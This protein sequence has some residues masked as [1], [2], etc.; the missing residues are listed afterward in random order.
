[1]IGSSLSHFKITAKLGEGGMG[2]V[3]QADD[4]KLGR[5]VA[6]KVLPEAVAADRERLAR[7]EREAKVLASLNHPNIAAIYGLEE[8]EDQ[9][10]LV[11]EMAD[12]ATLQELIEQGVP[13]EQALE[14]AG[15]V[16]EALEEAHDQGIVHRDLKPAN[17]K[18]ATNGKVKVLDFGLAKALD[19]QDSGTSGPSLS[20]SPTLTAQMTQAGVLLGTAAYM[21][22]EQARG[23]EATKQADIWAFGV[24]LWEML[25]GRQLFA[26]PTVSDTLAEVLKTDPDLGALPYETPANVHRVLRR[27]LE[28][29]PKKRLR[30]IGD[31][32]LELLEPDEPSRDLETEK[33]ETTSRPR[34]IIGLAGLLAG[35]ALGAALYSV[36]SVSATPAAREARSPRRSVLPFENQLRHPW[37]IAISPDGYSVAI[38]YGYGAEA[39]IELRNLGSLEGIPIPGSE[40]ALSP[41]FSPDGEWLAYFDD[42]ELRKVPVSGGSSSVVCEARTARSATWSDDGWIYFT[43]GE[44]RLARVPADGGESQDLTTESI[45]TPHALPEGRGVL[46]NISVGDTGSFRK[47]TAG[48]AVIGSDG[49]HKKLLDGG[50]AP[51]YLST[52]HLVFIRQGALFAVPFDVERLEVT[53]SEVQVLPRIWND[54]VWGV[55]TFDIGA[56]GTVVYVDGGNFAKTTPSWLDREGKTEPLN[57]PQNIHGTFQLS[58]DRSRLAIQIMEVEDQIHV[59]DFARR[60]LAQLTFD[61]PSRN[62]TW[63]HDGKEIFYAASREGRV[64]LARRSTDGIGEETLLLTADQ[65]ETME[66]DYV[67]PHTVSPDGRH[68]LLTSW[69]N[70]ETRADIWLLD[71]TSED[72]PQPLLKTEFNEIIPMFSPDGDYILYQSDKAGPYG[73]YVRPFPDVDQREWTISAQGGFDARW[74]PKG[75][76]ILYRVGA[77]RFMSVPYTMEPEFTPGAVSIVFDTDSHDSPG[78]SFDLSADGSRILVNRPEISLLDERPIILVT[79]WFTELEQL[80]PV[81]R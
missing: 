74:S 42:D 56:D 44:S 66:V 26:A 21:S 23:Q 71:L 60:S 10:F 25:S 62:P 50:F 4:M 73:L 15:Q 38:S 47:D 36:F 20:M 35:L 40:G 16:A 70:L 11:M 65:L 9:R 13:P 31:A 3:Y 63:S 18:V 17:I 76:E 27:C 69:G 80:V 37:E 57:I 67:A 6:I 8:A 29:D 51:K 78:F 32:R 72:D 7:F 68:I 46:V 22:P 1:M 45:F 43:H 58:P 52:G 28:R 30:D 79:D 48:I 77:M 2:V 54:S 39:P 34:W 41:F 33:L 24:V 61:G 49:T 64:T 81:T 19:P 75:D 55:A 14:I 59:Y 12:G 5:V 53:G